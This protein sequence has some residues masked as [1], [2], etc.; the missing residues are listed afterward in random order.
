LPYGIG[1]ED[2]A[3]MPDAT[4]A[5]TSV[6]LAEPLP[7]YAGQFPSRA[8]RIAANIARHFLLYYLDPQPPHISVIDSGVRTEVMPD[9]MT[10]LQT[11]TFV[12]GDQSFSVQHTKVHAPERRERRHAI[13]YCAAQR[14]V[15]TVELR[16]L[17]SGPLSD[18]AGSFFYHGY[19]SS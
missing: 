14:A 18:D 12:V 16:H 17:P 2:D 15:L 7:P 3:P 19:V 1:D 11:A 9:P 13:Y 10:S 8:Q 6:V 5:T 4:R